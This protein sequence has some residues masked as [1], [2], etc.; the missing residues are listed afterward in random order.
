MSGSSAHVRA[1]G[2]YSRLLSL[3]LSVRFMPHAVHSRSPK[4]KG[5]WQ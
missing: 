5:A 4:Q 2:K 3:G 1:F